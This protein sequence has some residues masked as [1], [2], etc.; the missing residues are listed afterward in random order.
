M[1]RFII[2]VRATSEMDKQT[3]PDLELFQAMTDYNVTLLEVGVLLFFNGL[4]RNSQ[5]TK[6]IVFHDSGS[7]TVQS[8]PFPASELVAG[9]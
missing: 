4:H 7:P 9:L 2:F 3:K 6:R 5:D 8:A 1:P